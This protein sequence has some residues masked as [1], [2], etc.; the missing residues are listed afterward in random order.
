ME[1]SPRLNSIMVR[2]KYINNFLNRCPAT[3]V[4]IPLWFDWN[5]KLQIVREYVYPS[6]NSIMVRLKYI[7]EKM[8]IKSYSQG[9]NSIMVRLKY[10]QL[11]IDFANI[12]SVSIPLWFDWNLLEGLSIIEKNIDVSIPLWF[13][14]NQ[15]F[16]VEIPKDHTMSQFHYGSIEI[17]KLQQ[18][19][20]NAL[21]QFHYGSI[22]IRR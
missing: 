16:G 2:L 20:A 11:V 1:T 8:N 4:S 3:R 5:K 15:L 10:F 13:D 6:L 19:V 7:M 14:W 12:Q 9:L 22:E 18:I 17:Y 21:S